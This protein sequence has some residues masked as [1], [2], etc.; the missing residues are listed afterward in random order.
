LYV[1]GTHHGAEQLVAV[2]VG[3]VE[4]LR[5]CE[6]ITDLDEISPSFVIAEAPQMK[7]ENGRSPCEFDLKKGVVLA[8]VGF[9]PLLVNELFDS[10]ESLEALGKT[11]ALPDVESYVVKVLETGGLVGDVHATDRRLHPALEEGEDGLLKAAAL[12]PLF[13]LRD[14]D[15]AELADI[16][17]DKRIGGCPSELLSQCLRRHGPAANCML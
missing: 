7:V 9:G 11:C 3:D 17:L 8:E 6:S 10:G 5:E 2:V 15:S 12:Q 4:D 1:A 16:F 14:E 13:K